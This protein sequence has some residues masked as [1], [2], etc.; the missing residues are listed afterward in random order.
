MRFIF[1]VAVILCC[2]PAFLG[3]YM[4]YVVGTDAKECKDP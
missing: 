2:G 1:S 4:V 3:D